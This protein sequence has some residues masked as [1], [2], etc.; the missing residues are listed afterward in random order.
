MEAD[1]HEAVATEAFTLAYQP[2]VD[3]IARRVTV[4][5]ALLR[6]RHPVH[7]DVPPAR[8]IPLAEQTGLIDPIFRWALR[9][10]CH[11]AA[12]WPA[13]IRVGLNITAGQFR[14]AGLPD[15][16]VAA[17]R[18]AGL[19]PARLELEITETVSLGDDPLTKTNF[20]SLRGAGIRIALDDFGNGYATLSQLMNFSFDRVKLGAAFTQALTSACE[21]HRGP[22]ILRS[23]I[24][25]SETLGIPWTAEGVETPA[26]LAMLSREG[27]TSMQGYLFS[28][29]LA[30][31]L[32]PAM[33]RRINDSLA[34]LVAERTSRPPGV[35]F[36]Q[37]AEMSNDV[38]IVTTA[39]VDAP[40]PRI[41]YVNPAFTRLTGF[42]AHEAIN[43]TPRI[44]QGPATSRASLQKIRAA[45]S[46]GQDVHEKVVNYSKSG[47]PYWL[48][49]R[50][51]PLRNADGV[52]THFAAIE[53]DVTMDKRRLDELARVAD[54]D[55]LTGIPNRRALLR[56]ITAEIE[57]AR[58]Q[59]A[60]R[61]PPDGPCVI[62]ID[63][64]HFK[65]VNDEF[66]HKAGDAVLCGVAD[67]LVANIRRSDI[68]GR[69]GGDEFAVCVAGVRLPDVRRLAESLHRAVAAAPFE[70][71]AGPLKITVS[72]G[73]ACL[74][75][76]DTL[77]DLLD[78]ADAAMY[79]AKRAGRNRTK[80]RVPE[81]SHNG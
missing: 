37:I 60:A 70:T 21:D 40:G 22:V 80:A 6:W 64:D 63:V 71:P 77:T 27:C 41:I 23:L 51:I 56:A 8:F 7:G 33:L 58:D 30:A 47:A 45:L 25:I 31:P 14:D 67:R 62:F 49:L 52:I 54:R 76:D 12:S 15:F 66:G 35:S 48:D 5:E 81:P 55:T 65:S 72:V 20:Q 78:R 10:A 57:A 68:V 1:L 11:D 4:L 43:A 46:Q 79:D 53:R 34:P 38:I 44:L 19:P 9:K 59:A 18:E 32:V 3:L 13:D 16:V 24:A 17:L 61:M 26:Q 29:P 42:T 69:V 36:F 75:K 50:I 2:Q 73:V 74:A 39:E 28:P